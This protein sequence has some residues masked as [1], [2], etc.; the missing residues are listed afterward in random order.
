MFWNSAK[1]SDTIVEGMGYR[2]IEDL[3]DFDAVEA[4]P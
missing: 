3:Q 1:L 4:S 2:M